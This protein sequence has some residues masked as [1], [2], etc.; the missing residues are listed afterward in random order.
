MAQLCA[1]LGKV[2]LKSVA[3]DGLIVPVLPVGQNYTGPKI[4]PNV[5]PTGLEGNR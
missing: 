4:E 5:G 2:D 1:K 3:L